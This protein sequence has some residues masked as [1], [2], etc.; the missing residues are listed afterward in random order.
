MN[1][2]LKALFVLGL[3]GS[4]VILPVSPPAFAVTAELANKCRAMA[5]KAYPRKLAG[6][7]S[8]TSGA[9]RKYFQNCIAKDGAVPEDTEQKAPAQNPAAK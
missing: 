3:L 2:A 8:G 6:S 9:E 4:W 1:K 7:K 5:I